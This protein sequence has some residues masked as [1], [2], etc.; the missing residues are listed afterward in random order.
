MVTAYRDWQVGDVINVCSSIDEFCGAEYQFIYPKDI[1]VTKS[2]DSCNPSLGYERGCGLHLNN[3]EFTFKLVKISGAT[4]GKTCNPQQVYKTI[5]SARTNSS[6]VARIVYI[7]TEQDRLDYQNAL[8]SGYSYKVIACITNPDGQAIYPTQLSIVSDSVVISPGIVITHT[9]DLIIKPWSWYD[10]NGAAVEIIKKLADI[11]GTITNFF[12][13]YGII[14]YQYI[15]TQVL[16]VGDN[17]VIRVNLRKTGLEGMAWPLLLKAAIIVVAIGLIIVTIGW[18]YD[19]LF[20]EQSQ[21]LTNEKLTNAGEELIKGMMDDCEKKICID[22]SLTQDQKVVCIKNCHDA[23]LTRWKDYQNK[24]YPDADHTPL[25][26]GKSE[27]Q[28]CY[29]AYLTSNRSS[30][31]YTNY[32]NCLKLQRENAIDKDKN[33]T[34]I[35]YPPD[36]PAGSKEKP[37]D[38]GKILLY[39]GLVIVGVVVITRK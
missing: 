18:I 6:G 3:V 29:D 28:K 36:A 17:V 27:I 11:D 33:N 12:A 10:P 1:N 23:D 7:V 16:T 22:P 39:G 20:G 21:G 4:E 24:I 26:T 34:I 30:T 19:Y 9:L 8:A 25:D 5:G 2:P 14:D 38:W 35:I 15:N 13:D 32:L 31:D 37:T